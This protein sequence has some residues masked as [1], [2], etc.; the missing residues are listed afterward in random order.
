MID[1]TDTGQPY[2]PQP[3]KV[4]WANMTYVRVIEAGLMDDLIAHCESL[5]TKKRGDYIAYLREWCEFPNDFR[6][7][8]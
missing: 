7:A 6:I 1:P 5:P 8:Q 3:R 2:K 4:P